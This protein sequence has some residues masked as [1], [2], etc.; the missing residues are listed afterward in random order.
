M[1]ESLYGYLVFHIESEN[2]PDQMVYFHPRKYRAHWWMKEK[3]PDAFYLVRC[4]GEEFTR[5]P[6]AF[7]TTWG[8]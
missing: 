6:W 8:C 7:D 2:T 1:S 5:V 3:N 4:H